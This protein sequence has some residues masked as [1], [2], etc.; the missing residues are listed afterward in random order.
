MGKEH[1]KQHNNQQQT[2]PYFHQ[3]W[4]QPHESFFAIAF[5]SFLNQLG[6]LKQL[7]P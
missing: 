1:R 7:N 4:D 2:K 5:Y 6:A 3:I